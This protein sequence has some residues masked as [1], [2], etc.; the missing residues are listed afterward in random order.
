MS[1]SFAIIAVGCG[2]A[3]VALLLEMASNGTRG[4]KNYG[5]GGDDS[6]VSRGDLE[7]WIKVLGEISVHGNLANYELYL[8]KMQP[9]FE[10]IF[11]NN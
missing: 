4:M 11:A 8:R 1:G 10:E 9:I 7:D 3:L 2:C 5:R 6:S